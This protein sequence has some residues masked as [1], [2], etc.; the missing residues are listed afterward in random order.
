[1]FGLKNGHILKNLPQNGETQRSSWVREKKKKGPNLRFRLSRLL[2]G[3]K[4]DAEMSW[5]VSTADITS[6]LLLGRA[7][8]LRGLRNFLNIDSPEHH[9][10]DGPKERGDQK[11][12]RPTFHPKRSGTICVQP[13]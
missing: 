5:L 7:E 10:I 1:M 8:V 4:S 11:G 13:D 9:N 2:K 6:D 3:H 12:R